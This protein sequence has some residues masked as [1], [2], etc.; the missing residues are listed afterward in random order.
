[1][2]S[3]K[4]LDEAKSLPAKLQKRDQDIYEAFRMVNSVIQDVTSF[5][6]NIDST[7]ASWYEEILKLADTI[8]A[9]ESVTRKT[10][11]QRNRNNTPSTTAQEHYKRAV[12]IPLLDCLLTQLNERFKGVNSYQAAC[13]CLTPSL[14]ASSSEQLSEKLEL[15]VLEV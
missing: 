7:F 1:M 15:N 10:S 5:R 2:S 8:G 3:L 6:A 11:L 12:A 9:I 14:I 13:L 4:T